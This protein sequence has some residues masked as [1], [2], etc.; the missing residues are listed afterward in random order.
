[1]ETIKVNQALDFDEAV[2]VAK[3]QGMKT[4]IMV[5]MLEDNTTEILG[6]K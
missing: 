1:M 2:K 5:K 6:W 3:S 4:V